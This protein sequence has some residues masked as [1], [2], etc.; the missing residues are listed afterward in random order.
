M[1]SL[2]HSRA[3]QEHLAD[4]SAKVLDM[5]LAACVFGRGRTPG[6]AASSGN[7]V[8]RVIAMGGN[9][10]GVKHAAANRHKR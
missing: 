6:K 3:N 8:S 5:K 4:D 2:V 1:R 10:D 7:L 9:T